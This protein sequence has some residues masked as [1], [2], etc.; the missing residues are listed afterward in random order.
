M[1]GD[2]ALWIKRLLPLNASVDLSGSQITVVPTQKAT[3]AFFLHVMEA[4]DSKKGAGQV[5]ANE[6]TAVLEGDSFLVKVGSYKMR[7]SKD[8]GFQ[9]IGPHPK[10]P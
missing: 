7:F 10:S 4:A 6:A 3:Q 2:G 9:W 5:L 1:N 8:G